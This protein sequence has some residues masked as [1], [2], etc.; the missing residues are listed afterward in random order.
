MKIEHLIVHERLRGNL[1]CIS[2][3]GYVDTMTYTV[4]HDLA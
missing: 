1:D 2:S 4:S 3:H